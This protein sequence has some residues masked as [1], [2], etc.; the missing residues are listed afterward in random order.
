M[1]DAHIRQSAKILGLPE[2][3]IGEWEFVFVSGA[4]PRSRLDCSQS[5]FLHA[6]AHLL[7]D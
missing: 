7:Q 5:D 1:A 6:S 2:K 4:S 3:E